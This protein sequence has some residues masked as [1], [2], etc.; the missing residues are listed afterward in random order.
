M[1]HPPATANGSWTKVSGRRSGQ[2]VAILG[3]KIERKIP[4][5]EQLKTR[6]HHI[7]IIGNALL[8]R[9]AFQ[10]SW[11]PCAG[12]KAGRNCC[13]GDIGDGQ[14]FGFGQNFVPAKPLRIS[15]SIDTS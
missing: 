13:F 9:E 8:L 1:R 6:R 2:R 12:G 4:I 5:A 11:M 14:N 3:V 15:R 10:G 7:G